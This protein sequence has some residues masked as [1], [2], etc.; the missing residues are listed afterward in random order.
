M[1]SLIPPSH[2]LFPRRPKAWTVFDPARIPLSLK[3]QARKTVIQQGQVW[4]MTCK[5][6]DRWLKETHKNKEEK[7]IDSDDQ[8]DS[9]KKVVLSQNQSVMPVMQVMQICS[10]L[11]L[12]HLFADILIFVR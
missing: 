5:I 11:W 6:S 4:L 8:F 10:T 1:K 12:K 2:C 9:S 3:D 7:V